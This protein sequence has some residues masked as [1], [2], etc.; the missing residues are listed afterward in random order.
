MEFDDGTREIIGV[1]YEVYN[2]LGYGFL[3]A[4]Y[5]EAMAIEFRRRGIKFGRQVRVDVMYKDEKCKDYSVDFIVG[6]V[7]VELKAKKF[8]GDADDAQIINYLKATGKKVG[9]L[10]NFGEEAD[11]KR[12]VFGL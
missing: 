2:T 11:F 4:V 3:E 8:L 7:V 10:M 5:E 1:F 6:D 9:L 12:R